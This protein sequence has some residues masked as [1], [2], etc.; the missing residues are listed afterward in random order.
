MS[1]DGSNMAVGKPCCDQL[2]HLVTCDPVRRA[3]GRHDD[4]VW[5][6]C[7]S[8]D[9]QDRTVFRQRSV[10]EDSVSTV[11]QCANATVF[12]K[13]Y[14]LAV[15]GFARDSIRI[16]GQ[17]RDGDHRLSKVGGVEGRGFH[18]KGVRGMGLSGTLCDS[19]MVTVARG[20][21]QQVCCPAYRRP[22]MIASRASETLTRR[23]TSMLFC[24]SGR[25]RRSKTLMPRVRL[26]DT[27][28]SPAIS[29]H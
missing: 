27:S 26:P 19:R 12:Q 1:R 14:D 15:F 2:V 6:A 28:T 5:S 13:T 4:G 24:H 18:G 7:V 29:C 16:A 25:S 10:I 3:N 17:G 8:N 23:A 21:H 20:R 11:E 9:L 22:R